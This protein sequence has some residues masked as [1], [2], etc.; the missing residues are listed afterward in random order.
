MVCSRSENQKIGDGSHDPFYHGVLPI[1]LNHHPPGL[2]SQRGRGISRLIVW[3]SQNLFVPLQMRN[4]I[5]EN[6]EHYHDKG[7]CHAGLGKGRSAQARSNA[8]I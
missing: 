3:R 6:N 4:R 5:V 2:A 7:K 1:N 8:E